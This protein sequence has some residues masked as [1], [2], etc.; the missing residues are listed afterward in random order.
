MAEAPGFHI[1]GSVVPAGGLHAGL[2]GADG[3]KQPLCRQGVPQ[4]RNRDSACGRGSD[5]FVEYFSG[6]AQAGLLPGI[7]H[8]SVA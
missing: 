6:R 5:V 4:Y 2:H 1:I 8:D 3:P 7:R